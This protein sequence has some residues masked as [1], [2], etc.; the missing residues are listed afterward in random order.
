VK[1]KAHKDVAPLTSCIQTG[2]VGGGAGPRLLGAQSWPCCMT[3]P[4][5]LHLCRLSH[6]SACFPLPTPVLR[7]APPASDASPEARPCAGS[8]GSDRSCDLGLLRRGAG[9]ARPTRRPPLQPRMDARRRNIS[10]NRASKGWDT[11]C[12]QTGALGLAAGLRAGPDP[13]WFLGESGTSCR[14]QSCWDPSRAS[15]SGRLLIQ[16]ALLCGSNFKAKISRN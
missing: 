11:A 10:R 1:G 4:V 15:C 2:A 12:A 14:Q 13:P 7:S 16:T 3:P 6:L 8:Q 5:S 9:T